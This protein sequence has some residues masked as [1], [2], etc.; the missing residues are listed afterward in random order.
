M[1]KEQVLRGE[2]SC[3][4]INLMNRTWILA[5]LLIYEEREQQQKDSSI[6]CAYHHQPLALGNAILCICLQPAIVYVFDERSDSRVKKGL[7]IVLRLHP[8]RI[9]RI[10]LRCKTT[11]Y[12]Y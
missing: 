12:T 2:Q 6:G 5:N 11:R 8:V 1:N 3:S 10:T 4:I 7:H 9:I